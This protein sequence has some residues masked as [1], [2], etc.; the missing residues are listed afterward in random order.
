MITFLLLLKLPCFHQKFYQI[1]I[2]FHQCNEYLNQNCL[3]L[4]Q[5]WLYIKREYLSSAMITKKCKLSMLYCHYYIFF[6]SNWKWEMLYE[7][8]TIVYHC[9]IIAKSLQHNISP[10]FTYGLLCFYSKVW[11]YLTCH[12]QQKAL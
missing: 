3:I 10:L 11:I 7:E 5:N 8:Q 12:Q 4:L 1:L 9:A 6:V 2:M